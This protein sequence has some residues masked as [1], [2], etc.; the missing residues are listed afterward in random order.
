MAEIVYTAVADATG[1]HGSLFQGV[2]F[3]L[4][5]KV[6]QRSRFIEEV[7]ANGGEVMYSE[8]EAEVKIV[9]PARKPQLPGR[10]SFQYIEN[11][12]RNGALEDLENYA[13]G[14][15]VGTIRAVGSRSQPV[16]S[17]RTKF[18]AQDDHELLNWVRTFE[19]RGG[20]T[21]GN[22]IYKQLE[23]K[24]PRHTW[25]SW[26]DRWVK[27]LKDLP[28]SA[29]ISRDAPPTPPADQRVETSRPSTVVED[30]MG[31]R[32]PFTTEDGRSLLSVGHQIEDLDPDNRRQA[33]SKWAENQ[34]HP[35]DHS[36]KDW[37][38]L[39][40]RTIGPLFR[41]QQRQQ[42]EEKSILQGPTDAKA[43]L[44]GHRE[45]QEEAP[46]PVENS[47]AKKH[48]RE[49]TVPRSPSYHPESPTRRLRAASHERNLDISVADHMDGAS[50]AQ[51]RFKSPAKRKRPAFE[52][53][54]EI[55]SSSPLQ[56][57]TS[58]KR[59]R[60]DS[61]PD[62][63][64]S[65]PGGNA[66]TKVSAKEIPDTY[67]SGKPGAID[68]IEIS[69]EDDSHSPEEELFCSETSQSLSP[70]LGSSP[71]RLSTSLDRNV[72]RTQA[73]F[74]DPAPSIEYELAAPE[75]GWQD[76]EDDGEDDQSN[77]EEDD[78]IA[79]SYKE[80]AE[81]D[82]PAPQCG[83]PDEDDDQD[84]DEDEDEDDD[85]EVSAKDEQAGYDRIL[86]EEVG[87]LV[88]ADGEYGDEGEPE[89][90]QEISSSE[91]SFD[92]QERK[93]AR[94]M[95]MEGR[96][97][98]SPSSSSSTVTSRNPSQT[99]IQYTTQGIITAQTQEPDLS[100][101]EPEGGWDQ[102]LSSPP[103]SP[104]ISKQNLS[105]PHQIHN[106]QAPPFPTHDPAPEPE[107]NYADNVDHFIS[108]MVAQ[109]HDEDD[110][111]L[112]LRCTNMDHT[113]TETALAYMKT[114]PRDTTTPDVPGFWTEADDTDLRGNNASKIKAL[115]LKHG[116]ESLQMRWQFLEHYGS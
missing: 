27:T 39:W 94:E 75:D 79:L 62:E 31:A 98:S 5:Q 40:E 111:L 53:G 14:P 112:A 46:L 99:R 36:A 95:G 48:M 60:R 93:L 55:P 19:Q 80:A 50:D 68:V 88:E 110:I 28:Q 103:A 42:V 23:A 116:K 81:Y 4:S 65:S 85:D 45:T 102:V 113:L 56:I 47:P 34:E 20:A 29:F 115:E 44:Y 72:S 57:E 59:L 76:E 11:S 10:F 58:N 107:P 38:D 24:N 41:K 92:T 77:A 105:Q 69:D 32:K 89:S 64:L 16:K 15:P 104:F 114:H 3:W 61:L 74:L 82:L 86:E 100:L 12:V 51:D 8:E 6:P 30:Q 106:Q 22:E 49:S 91:F 1:I 17:G 37:E 26:R 2:K 54:E 90:Q 25:Q 71:R 66:F 18:T 84:E 97:S 87:G 83:W 101:A 9:D 13:V 63:I 108:Y 35:E 7:K 109:G 43:E 52:D 33:W 73:A 70:E 21:S 96:P 78:G 67:A